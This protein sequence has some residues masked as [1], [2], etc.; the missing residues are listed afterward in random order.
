M[1]NEFQI[2]A[3]ISTY[4]DYPTLPL[5]LSSVTDVVDSVIIADGAY[6]KYYQNFVKYDDTAKPWST[7][8]TL[9]I[10]KALEPKLPPVK[11]IE[12]P[13][14]EPWL[15]QTVKRSVM[16]DAVADKDWFIILDSDEMLYGNT[17]E[18]VNE[19][20]QSGCIAGCMPLFSPGMGA[21]HLMPFWHPRI[22]LK[23]PGMYYERKHWF[24]CDYA[25]RVIEQTYP[26]WMTNRCVMAHFK[27]FR[28]AKRMAPHSSY[29]LDMSVD[30]W[31]E[32]HS[33][34]FKTEGEVN[35]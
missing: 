23:L 4:N 6:K 17:V 21:N 20:M 11:I 12:C 29:M 24:L 31:L 9:D 25:H 3:L 7:D 22:F 13:D 32:P 27:V 26:M 5:A 2:H 33:Q 15:N 16:L 30:G 34:M 28:H 35:T 8:G 14:G 19:V 10:I 18:G 1:T